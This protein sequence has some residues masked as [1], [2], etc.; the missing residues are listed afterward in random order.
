MLIGMLIDVYIRYGST[1]IDWLVKSTSA[2]IAFWSYLII[3]WATPIAMYYTMQ[4]KNKANIYLGAILIAVFALA[5]RYA[6]LLAPHLGWKN[7][8]FP[9][10]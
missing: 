10:H 2:A 9:F 5:L 7:A 1:P 4:R 8:G 3:G 6:I